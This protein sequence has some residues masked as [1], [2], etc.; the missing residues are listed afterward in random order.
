MIFLVGF[1]SVMPLETY[2]DFLEISV[3]QLTDYLSVRGLNTFGRKIELVAK[4]FAAMELKMEIIESTE[5]QQKQLY[6]TYE[7]KLLKL[8]I[9]DPNTIP[10]EKRLDD[11]TTWPRITL[12]NIFSYIL[13]KKDFDADY[14]GKYKDQKAYSFFDSGFVGP[15]LI[16][17][18]TSKKD[19]T[20][21]YCEVRASQSIHENK[22]LW[23]AFKSGASSVVEIL[24]AW[25]SC[26]AGAYEACNHIIA[27]LY[28]I[29]YANNKGWCTP[30]CTEIACN[31]NR[32]TKKDIEPTLITDLIVRKR[33]R[34]DEDKES[35]N[36]ERTRMKDL[37]KF[38]PRI[39]N[40]RE[41]NE[42]KF[43]SFLENVEKL[44]DNAVIFKSLESP[45]ISAD[46]QTTVD[47]EEVC[48]IVTQENPQAGD[49]DLT[50]IF[51]EKLL[52]LST[53]KTIRY[54]Q[55]NTREQSNSE[56]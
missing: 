38:D 53:D 39:E 9:P 44:H 6:S 28:K 2:E 15:V 27:T 3:K 12:G 35:K 30:A 40:H 52:T 13:K 50:R 11:I 26:M 7:K 34:T 47:I 18:L 5:E 48:H 19:T 45:S 23:I 56:L 51:L 21:I 4:A 32:S 1:V 29:E 20:F 42:A 46:Q 10:K 33:L 17:N 43:K 36:R 22:S 55:Y 16:Y 8:E 54:I 31:W 49:T 41:F 24:S 37:Q 14:I 25:C